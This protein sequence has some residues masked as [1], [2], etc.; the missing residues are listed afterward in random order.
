MTE[1]DSDQSLE[2]DSPS[3]TIGALS[4]LICFSQVKNAVLMKCCGKVVCQ[5]CIKKW[6]GRNTSCPHCRKHTTTSDVINI[7]RLIEDISED[8]NTLI[9]KPIQQPKCNKHPN[10]PL[11]YY[12]TTCGTII[13]SD[14][15]IMS[16]EVLYFFF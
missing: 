6:I 16:L 4:C 14:C 1:S 7:T 11:S 9:T 15:A 3:K 8:V 13:C 5:G 12:C 2:N 10:C